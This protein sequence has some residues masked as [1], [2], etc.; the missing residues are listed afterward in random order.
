MNEEKCVVNPER[1]CLGL[2]EAAKLDGRIKALEVW[3]DESKK[4]HEDFYD[5]QKGQI[6]RDAKLDVR[7]ENIR[8]NVT[9]LVT[10]QESQ[11]AKPGKRLDAMAEKVI[12]LVVAA[13]VGFI[14]ARIG[15]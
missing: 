2:A 6:A 15:L 11:Q 12:M 1:D 7:L 14:L 4:F 8:D 5:W 13:V 10:W 3:K 9:K